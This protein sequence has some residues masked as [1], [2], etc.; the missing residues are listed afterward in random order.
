MLHTKKK[1]EKKEKTQTSQEN[2]QLAA[3]QTF[4]DPDEEQI[5]KSYENEAQHGLGPLEFDPQTNI[6]TYAIDQNLDGEYQ[7]QFYHML[8]IKPYASEEEIPKYHERE[9]EE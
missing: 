3:S 9:E 2:K 4:Y 6:Y 7:S 1:G 5:K 8:K